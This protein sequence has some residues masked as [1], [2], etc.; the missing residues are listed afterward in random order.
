MTADSRKKTGGP[1]PVVKPGI[2]E[3]APYQGGKA[4]I[5]G[6]ERAIKLSAN[7]GALGPSPKAMAAF[8]AA[9]PDLHRYPDGSSRILRSA[10]SRFSGLDMKR[11][12]CGAGSDELLLLLMRAYAGL[13]DEVLYS[14]HGFLIYPIF[15]H[16][17]GATPVKAEET[18]LTA[19]VDALLAKVTARTRIVFLANP[20]NP[21][22]SYLPTG[23]LRR[24]RAGLP[25]HVL[26]VLDSAYAEYVDRDDYTAGADLV[27]ENSNVVMTR[28]F[29]KI[30][31]L[32]AMR[33]GWCYAPAPIVDVLNRL[34]P[35]FNT[36]TPGQLAGAAAMDDRDHL[37]RSQDH[38][39]TWREY[40]GEALTGMGFRVFP[41]VANFV[42]V[43]FGA[44][45]TEAADR[46]E[47]AL[48]RDGLIPRWVDHYGLRGC[49]RITIGQEAE[50]RAVVA[51]L[52]RLVKDGSHVG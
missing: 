22:G 34:R 30:F 8:A 5:A 1:G 36:T 35:P 27:D 45:V 14:A 46:A 17:V 24:L 43:E 44:G 16:S 51:A 32:G 39:T 6:R 7:E 33:L 40:L 37:R 29:S 13:G 28:T 48:L 4:R 52:S 47:A 20:N 9:A 21:T 38:N 31:G 41:S 19:S 23:E 25:D 42:L 2:M 12:V 10:I 18:N 26:L 15:A 11:I 3:I 49:L 50:M